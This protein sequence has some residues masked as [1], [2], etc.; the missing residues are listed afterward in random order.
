M[1]SG[2]SVMANCKAHVSALRQHCIC[3][4]AKGESLFGWVTANIGEHGA[5]TLDELL[6]HLT[7][8]RSHHGLRLEVALE[9][10]KSRLLNT[11]HSPAHGKTPR[12]E[13]GLDPLLPLGPSLL[14][15]RRD[16]PPSQRWCE[17]RNARARLLRAL[18][19]LRRSSTHFQ[20][21]ILK[22]STVFETNTL[23]IYY[24]MPSLSLSRA[25]KIQHFLKQWLIEY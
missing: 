4:C 3:T 11:G 20:S 14:S 16:G 8:H 12:T 10:T 17:H 1:T 21:Q 18:V 25:Y 9:E 13:L 15:N 19:R 5:L 23:T 22:N 6:A 24:S 7:C 2:G